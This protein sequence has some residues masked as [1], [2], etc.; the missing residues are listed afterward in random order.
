ME[1]ESSKN[2]KFSSLIDEISK[3]TLYSLRNMGIKR[4]TDIQ[5]Q[6][7]PKLLEGCDIVASAKTGSGKTLA[8]LIP[9]VVA[10]K[11][12]IENNEQGKKLNYCL[13]KL[14]LNK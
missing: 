13:S 10:V 4:M 2:P 11:K 14:F 5:S 6:A 7:L 1:S 9:L 12:Q 8:F 3:P